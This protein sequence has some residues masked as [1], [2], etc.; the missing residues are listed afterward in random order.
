MDVN[1]G[2]KNKEINC[3]ILVTTR[4]RIWQ[5]DKKSPLTPGW[6]IMEL[7]MGTQ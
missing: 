5:W 2:L 1:G 6:F 7:I 4:T 3:V